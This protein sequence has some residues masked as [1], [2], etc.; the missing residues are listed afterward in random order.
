MVLGLCVY[1]IIVE[2][3]LNQQSSNNQSNE[4]EVIA[5]LKAEARDAQEKLNKAEME[6]KRL[7]EEARQ[8]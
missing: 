4:S 2:N 5:R 1:L 6:K 8:V 3:E 7:I